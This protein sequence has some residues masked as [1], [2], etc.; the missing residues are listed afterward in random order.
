MAETPA[1]VDELKHQPGLSL[2]L[3]RI[4]NSAAASLK[5]PVHSIAQ[6][7]VIIGRRPLSSGCSCCSTRIPR[8]RAHG[9]AAAASWPRRVAG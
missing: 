3:L 1:I 4:A 2:N 5:S 9:L 8:R 6:A 7:V